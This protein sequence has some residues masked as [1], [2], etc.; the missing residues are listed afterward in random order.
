M[1]KSFQ[2]LVILSLLYSCGFKQEQTYNYITMPEIGDPVLLKRSGEHFD[3]LSTSSGIQIDISNRHFK[4]SS[5]CYDLDLLSSIK[6]GGTYTQKSLGGRYFTTPQAL[7]YPFP[8]RCDENAKLGTYEH[9]AS[10]IQSALKKIEDKM[11][12]INLS[13]P[14]V[15]L[16][17][18]PLIKAISERREGKNIYQ[19]PKYQVNNAYYN[20]RL[21]EIT[22][23]PQGRTAYGVPFSSIPLWNI[24]FVPIHEYGHHMFNYYMDGVASKGI[25]TCFNNLHIH[26]NFQGSGNRKLIKALNEA[27]ADLIGKLGAGRSFRFKRVPCFRKARDVESSKF[28]DNQDKTLDENTWH[29]FEKNIPEAQ[30]NCESRNVSEIHHFGAIIAHGLYEVMRKS[31]DFHLTQL[32]DLLK[33][34][35][36]RYSPHHSMKR[37][38]SLFLESFALLDLSVDNICEI[39]SNQFPLFSSQ[40]IC[41]NK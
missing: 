37:N 34:F 33:N 25:N 23:L 36:S 41:S 21:K 8:Y 32:I 24:P 20:P 11:N 18:A 12:D 40:E 22:F 15:S 2:L 31:N 7:E 14:K 35:K 13:L 26:S 19:T 6:L 39:L 3:F 1:F 4:G 38:M 16:N 9:A 28:A 17:V 29:I 5:S 30:R 27:F 10:S